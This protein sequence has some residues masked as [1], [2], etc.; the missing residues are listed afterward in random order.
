MSVIS[1]VFGQQAQIFCGVESFFVPL[2]YDLN[3]RRHYSLLRL[4]PLCS[5]HCIGCECYSLLL[6]HRGRSQDLNRTESNL[7]LEEESEETEKGAGSSGLAPDPSATDPPETV[8]ESGGV[9]PR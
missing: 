9:D 2:V 7:Q 8:Q 5:I 4:G 6:F 1:A 3:P